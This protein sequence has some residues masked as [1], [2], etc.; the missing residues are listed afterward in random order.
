ML[1][2]QEMWTSLEWVENDWKSKEIETAHIG[3]M[4]SFAVRRA[5]KFRENCGTILDQ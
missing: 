4:R 5:K 1:V 3:N 2:D